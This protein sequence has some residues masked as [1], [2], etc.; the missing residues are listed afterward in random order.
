MKAVELLKGA[1]NKFLELAPKFSEHAESL[2]NP[3][4]VTKSQV[5]LGSVKNEEQATKAE[6]NE[7]KGN[8]ENP[9]SV[10]KEQ[11]GLGNLK[12]SEQATKAEFLSHKENLENPH[13][14]TKEQIGLGSVKNEEQ[15]TK[16][17]FNEH[18]EN[19][20]NPHGVT[21]EQLGLGSVKNAEQATAEQYEEHISGKSDRHSGADIMYSE[22]KSVNEK[23]EELIVEG[24][25]GTMY[26]SELSERDT[27][28]QHPI[29]A[30]SGLREELDSMAENFEG[31]SH[32]TLSGRDEAGAHPISAISGLSEK[33]D[34][35]LLF[36]G[37]TTNAT[38]TNLTTNTQS[39]FVDKGYFRLPEGYAADV[40]LNVVAAREQNGIIKTKDS[41]VFRK[42]LLFTRIN[43]L[44]YL[45]NNESEM[46][47]ESAG[48]RDNVPTP[49]S[50]K[51][52]AY[53]GIHYCFT[54]TGAEG[55]RVFWRGFMKLRNFVKVEA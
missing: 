34:E 39:P 8:R 5:G 14:V 30:I 18:R 3:H 15:A 20:E 42:K 6:F 43:S 19:L 37:I 29:S 4:A 24:G 10:T 7:H 40:E 44:M 17:E 22:T 32:S 26:H 41:A 46:E 28:N 12:N 51:L 27:P 38:A 13:A 45:S 52:G 21:K 47:G 48:D 36:E 25:S 50:C 1:I 54:V 53:D 55:H 9:H 16:A 31:I 23:I 2:E 33:I 35:I 49:Y 11:V